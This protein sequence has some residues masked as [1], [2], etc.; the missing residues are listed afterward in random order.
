MN[1]PPI[2]GIHHLK[3]A[4]SDLA[5]SLNFYEQAFNAERIAKFDH[6]RTS[7]G[8]LYAYILKVPG[9]GTALEL[10]LNAIRAQKHRHFDS[11][12]L[13]VR[14]RDTLA[15]W[16]DFLTA[17]GIPHSPIITAIQAWLIVV[18]DPDGNRLRLY[19]LETHGPELA[20]DEGNP[21]IAE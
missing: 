15:R 6:R 11:V 3:F 19:T 4:V 9:L 7:D 1:A 20:P 14:D 13:A 21:W 17:R 10:R 2:E 5:L 18:E 16:D 12:T 8:S